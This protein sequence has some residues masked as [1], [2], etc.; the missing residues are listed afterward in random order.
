VYNRNVKLK[1]WDTAGQER[2][3]HISKQFIQGAEGVLLIF[4]VSSDLLLNEYQSG[5]SK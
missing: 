5:L 2:Y 4:D 1:I 3:F